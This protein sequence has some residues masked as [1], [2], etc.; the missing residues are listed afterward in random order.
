MVFQ[1]RKRVYSLR[2]SRNILEWAYKW[3]KKKGNKF[4]PDQLKVLEHDLQE[5]DQALLEGKREEADAL[6]RKV[7]DFGNTH[8][9]KS[10]FEYGYE[11][12]AALVFALLIAAVVRT[13]W[14]EPYE[15]PTGS[16]RPTFEEQDHVTV[17]KT[18]FGLNIPF[19]TAHFYF[20][21]NLVQRSSIFIFSG[22]NLPLS[23]T[24][25]TFFYIFPYKKRYIKRC[26]GK[27]GDILYFYGGKIYGM[28]KNGNLIKELLDSSWLK[29][30]EHIPFLSFEG[31][32]STPAPN[33]I[34]FN[35]MH[36][37]IGRLSVAS[38]ELTGEIFNGKDWVKDQPNAQAGS[39]HKLSTYSDFWGMRNYA[40]VRLLTKKEVQEYT[41]ANI[42]ELEEGILYLELRHTPS[43]TYPIPTFPKSEYGIGVL[44][45]PYTTIIPVQE[46]HLKTIFENMYTARFVIQ[47]GK[48]KRYSVNK[49]P[50]SHYSPSFPGVPDGCYEFYYGKAFRIGW[51]GI[52]HALPKDHPLYNQDPSNIQ[53]LF[54]LGI[55]MNTAYAPHATNQMAIPHRYAYFREGDLYLLGAPI[56]KKEDPVLVAFNEREKKKEKQSSKSRPYVA[57]Q[58]Y[59]PPIKEGKLDT[60]FMKTFGL[61][62]PE[63]NYL[64]LG[65]NHAMS[66]DSRVFGF[67][68]EN[69]LQGAPSFIIWP[70]GDRWGF[71]SQKPYPIINLPR[72]IVW[73]TALTICIIWFIFHRQKLRKSI[74]KIRKYTVG[75]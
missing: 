38:G 35:Q 30:I 72:L 74:F 75:R 8:F 28:D 23:D 52:S 12:A 71:P 67:V 51:G 58:D 19:Q 39:H 16:M 7:E 37:P 60:D 45:T 46:R 53:K 63:K 61:K 59:G 70:P 49:I 27:P 3:Y 69:N 56:Y 4:P 41:N 6:A 66:A 62:I 25:T 26:M 29:K 65:D 1:K 21:P 5:L 18:A 34:L 33:Q 57:F 55:E 40:M 11:L 54:N 73:G 44:L 31:E 14:F 48:A 20:D 22:D 10:M 68:P 42:N 15:I 43:L 24:D 2:K 47:D 64:A 17:T 13:M 9:K 32:I 36:K 50:F